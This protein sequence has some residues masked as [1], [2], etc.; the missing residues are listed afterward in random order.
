MK[1]LI[2]AGAYVAV[3]AA[4]AAGAQTEPE[5]FASREYGLYFDVPAAWTLER[6]APDALVAL[7]DSLGLLEVR[8]TAQ[9]IAQK[10]DVREYAAKLERARGVADRGREVAALLEDPSFP[11]KWRDV[12]G[13][14]VYDDTKATD[15]ARKDAEEAKTRRPVSVGEFAAGEEGPISA[16]PEFLAEMTT[17]LY[18]EAANTQLVIYVIGGGVGYAVTISAARDDFYAALPLARDVIA[19][20]RLDKLTG[21]RYALPDAEALSRAKQGIIMGKVLSNGRAIAGVAVNL[22]VSAEVYARGVP[23]YRSLSNGYGEYSLTHLPPQR[24]YLLEAYGVSDA[25]ERFRSVQPITNMEETAGR[26]TFVNVEVAH[27]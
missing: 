4:A 15:K 14:F 5:R 11:E 24:Y 22:Y 16:G 20:M 27:Q 8:V 2:K 13:P 25:G 18:E 19:A 23:S 10:K 12:L 3:M 6:N 21:G 9:I 7:R 26:V 1:P 17:R